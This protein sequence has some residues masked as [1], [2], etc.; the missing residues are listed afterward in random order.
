MWKIISSTVLALLCFFAA[1]PARALNPDLPPGGNFDLSHFYLGLPV[2]SSGGTNGESAS[3]PATQLVAGYSN[4]LYFYTGTDGAM[5]FW[6]P[7]TGA[8]TSGS[9]YPRSELRELLYP[10]STET[11]WFA[12]GLHTLNAQCKVLQVPST[13]KVIIGQIHGYTGAALPMVK[14]EYENGTMYGTVK[15]NANDDG[16]DYDF[17]FGNTSLSNTITYEITALNGL[18]TIVINGVTN[19]MNIFQTDTNWETNTLYFKAGDYC[20]DN[21]G[22]SN[23]GARVSFYSL[24]IYHAPSITT[25]P[26]NC[27]AFVGGSNTFTVSAL[28][29]PPF[30][31]RWQFN[32]TNLSGATNTFLTLTNLKTTN[33]GSYTVVVTDLTGSVTSSVAMLTINPLTAPVITNFNLSANQTTCTVGG[34][35]AASQPCVLQS[36]SNLTPPVTWTS[37]AT[38]SAGTNGLFSFTNAPITNSTQRFYRVLS[39]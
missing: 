8:T 25:P 31:Y 7:V 2:D 3:I 29:N 13:G 24:S 38:N 34:T 36:A 16:S 5:T 37:V 27:S 15:T 4:A 33:A 1:L 23:E 17:I 9:S 28:G 39:P 11:N 22:T 18:I 20:Q 35:A 21:T 14:I 10:P 19:S 12:Y 30:T 6:A 32:G 26:T